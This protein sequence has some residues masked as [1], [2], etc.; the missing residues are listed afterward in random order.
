[1]WTILP[2]GSLL[3]FVTRTKVALKFAQLQICPL[4][5]VDASVLG[6]FRCEHPL[7]LLSGIH[8]IYFW[9]PFPISRFETE[10][11]SASPLRPHIQDRAI[12]VSQAWIAT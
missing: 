9:P 7:M 10:V 2:R 1:M 6:Y 5:C 11:A 3:K 4:V 8:S 12:P